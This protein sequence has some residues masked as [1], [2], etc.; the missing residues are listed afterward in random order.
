MP[1]DLIGKLLAEN[2]PRQ[3]AYVQKLI[4]SDIMSHSYCFVGSAEGAQNDF[5]IYF[6]AHLLCH[7]NCGQCK[8][9]QAFQ[10]N[11]HLDLKV[12]RSLNN[13]AISL[14]QIQEGQKHLSVSPQ[15]GQYRLLIIQD[16]EFLSLASA[17][18]LLKTLEEPPKKSLIM[19]TTGRPDQLL[20]T[21]RSR[22]ATIILPKLPTKN[23][24]NYQISTEEQKWIGGRFQRLVKLTAKNLDD[25]HTWQQDKEFWLEFIKNDTVQRE[26]MVNDRFG[27]IKE[28]RSLGKLLSTGLT[29][30][31]EVLQTLI[32]NGEE[33][34]TKRL[35]LIRILK[36]M[37]DDNVNVKMIL[38]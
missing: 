33:K 13:Q 27:S 17:N 18:A 20:K 2:Y 15:L 10:N 12:I 25:F 16:T 21:V 24:L 6:A 30:L 28:N 29:N 23:L 14:K 22:T 11:I 34:S 1:E 26:K 31:E 9:C 3:I 4:K 38:D 35:E 5:A 32:Q 36:T 37:L 8:N 7:K 19:L